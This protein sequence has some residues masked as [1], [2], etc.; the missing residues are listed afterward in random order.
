[1]TT[2]LRTVLTAIRQNLSR[3]LFA[4]LTAAVAGMTEPVIPTLTV[5]FVAGFLQSRSLVGSQECKL[6]NAACVAL[7]NSGELCD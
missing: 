4:C 3:L 6:K 7:I 1:M 2:A 5:S